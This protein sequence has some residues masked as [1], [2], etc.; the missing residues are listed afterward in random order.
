M[1]VEGEEVDLKPFAE[2]ILSDLFVWHED[3]VFDEMTSSEIGP[4][5]IVDLK[6]MYNQFMPPNGRL[7]TVVKHGQVK[8]IGIV[9]LA[10]IDMKNRQAEI[11]GGIGLKE[12]RNKGYGPESL[13]LMMNWGINQLGLQRIY[14]Y[15]KANNQESCNMLVKAGFKKETEIK[16][17]IYQNGSFSNRILMGYTLSSKLP[18]NIMEQITSFAK[19]CKEDLGKKIHDGHLELLNT[20]CEFVRKQGGEE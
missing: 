13:R 3:P 12:T 4:K 8:P 18:L 5:S 7:F 2:K 10:N 14:A 19:Y 6:N 20:F 9:A 17:A 15:V 1:T 16:D 11:F